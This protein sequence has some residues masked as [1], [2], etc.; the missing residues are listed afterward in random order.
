MS[1]PSHQ[2]PPS[3]HLHTYF[4]SS[5]SA[6]LRLALHLKHLPFTTTAIHLLRNEQSAPTYTALNPSASVPTLTHTV[7]TT[8]TSSPTSTDKPAPTTVTIPQS[9][10]ALEYLDEAFPHTRALYPPP[11]QPAQRALVRTLVS[12][13]ACDV[14]PLTNART[15]KAVNAVGG[16]GQAWA[17]EWTV[18]GLDAFERILE[19]VGGGE[20]REGK[21]V[22]VPDV[23]LSAADVCLVPAVWAAQRWG[24]DLERWPR[25][26]AVVRYME[27][28]PEVKAAHW[29]R[30]D[31]TPEEFREG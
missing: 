2:Q 9:I 5:C 21:A 23:G 31:D 4:R 15:M 29:R 18:R 16:E 30:Q 28:L 8:T 3:L 27:G 26:M 14:Q 1:S 25:I 24:C 11:T 10:P 20:E 19:G 6:R 17:R 22:C 12:V 13:I 7:A